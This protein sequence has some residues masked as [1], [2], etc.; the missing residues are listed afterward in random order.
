MKQTTFKI[1]NIEYDITDFDIADYLLD[2]PQ[3]GAGLDSDDAFAAARKDITDSLPKE[4]TITIGVD[5]KGD[6][7][8]LLDNL[9]VSGYISDITGW[10]VK[11]F[12]TQCID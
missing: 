3:V 1:I 10:C 6:I 8:E 7:Y 12:N 2:H 5:D 11:S 4:L 9:D